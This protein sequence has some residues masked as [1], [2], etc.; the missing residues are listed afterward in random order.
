[1][2]RQKQKGFAARS[3]L[4]KRGGPLACELARHPVVLKINDWIFC[5]GG[6]LPHHGEPPCLI[7]ALYKLNAQRGFCFR[8]VN[9]AFQQNSARIIKILFNNMDCTKGTMLSQFVIFL[10]AVEYGIERMNI[11]VSTWMKSSGEDSDH[12]TDIPFIATRGYD[13]VVW[14]R[15]YSQDSAERTRRALLVR[16]IIQSSN[17]FYF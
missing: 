10:S 13:S 3:S 11:E 1:M 15:M 12:E 14:S 16:K 4:F 17:H 6:L 5:H 8:L 7:G 9:P 2:L